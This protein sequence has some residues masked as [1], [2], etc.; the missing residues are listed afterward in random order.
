MFLCRG[1]PQ[2]DKEFQSLDLVHVFSERIF[3]TFFTESSVFFKLSLGFHCFPGSC[4]IQIFVSGIHSNYIIAYFASIWGSLC[5]CSR[6]ALF[7]TCSCW[8]CSALIATQGCLNCLRDFLN[9]S[10]IKSEMGISSICMYDTGS[11]LCNCVEARTSF[12]LNS[13]SIWS[14]LEHKTRKWK[15]RGEIRGRFGKGSLSK[16]RR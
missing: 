9:M 3:S 14:K 5:L 4:S 16:R 8:K 15:G 13:F 12:L 11:L 10:R 2:T 1:T 7:L 6:T